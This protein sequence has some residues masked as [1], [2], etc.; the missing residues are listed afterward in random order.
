MHIVDVGS[1]FVK[2]IRHIFIAVFLNLGIWISVRLNPDYIKHNMFAW[3]LLLIMSYVLI[4]S[5]AFWY[6]KLPYGTTKNPH[7]LALYSAL[8]LVATIFCFL[9]VSKTLKCVLTICALCLG[10]FLLHSSSRPAWIG[11][12][13]SAF[14]L[15]I[16]VQV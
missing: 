13:V 9:K 15:L 6:F 7:Y 3:L 2:E 8:M 5:I 12:I 1:N 14:L 16:F 4:Q 10:V 11:L